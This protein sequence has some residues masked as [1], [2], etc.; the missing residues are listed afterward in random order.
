VSTKRILIVEDNYDNRAIYTEIFR[1]AGY[2]V[3]EAVN[4]REGVA[5]AREVRPE[6]IIMDLS[7]PVFTGWEALAALKADEETASIP[8]F[9]LSAHVLMEGDYQKAIR[10]GF[11]GYITK[12]VEP[13]QVLE[14]V[15]EL[16]GAP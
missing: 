11:V 1:Y 4:G 7:M 14:R 9:A 15:R 13:K 2:E 5:R 10:S 12:P 8:V 16:I 6:V 3:I